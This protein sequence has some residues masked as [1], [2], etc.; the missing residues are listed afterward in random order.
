[1]KRAIGT[2]AALGLPL[3]AAG[4]TGYL[5][6]GHPA[7]CAAGCI[8]Y[9]FLPAVLA[10]SLAAIAT[11]PLGASLAHHLPARLLKRVFAGLLLAV[12]ADLAAELFR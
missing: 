6:A 4:L 5:M 7:Q 8:G 11:A 1:M 12:S 9:V 2:A 3:A 10:I